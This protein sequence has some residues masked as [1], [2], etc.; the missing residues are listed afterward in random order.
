[1]TTHRNTHRRRT[2]LALGALALV[3]L[4]TALLANAA[5]PAPQQQTDPVV[6][7]AVRQLLD[8]TATAVAQ[9]VQTQTVVAAFNQAVIATAA[10]QTGTAVAQIRQTQ[11][12]V[13]AFNQA[14]TAT[15]AVQ[16]GT[17]VAQI[18]QTQTVVEAFNQ[19]V[20]ATAAAQTVTA[21][22]Q[23]RQTQ[24]VVEA[25]N[26][27]LT[28]TKQARVAFTATALAA[29]TPVVRVFEDGVPMVQVP[30]GCFMMGMTDAEIDDLV[31][32]YGDDFFSEFG[33][34]HQQCFEAPFWI[35]RT[36]VTQADFVR[37]GG[38]QFEQSI[39]DGAD[40]PVE[41]IDWFEAR[42]FCA[43]RGARLPTEAEWEYA[44]RGP[45]SLIYPWGN[46][47]DEGRAVLSG[48]TNYGTAQV[49]SRPAGR[50]WVG[51]DDMVGNVW[52][53]TSSWYGPY[54]YSTDD[55]R[56]ANDDYSYGFS[57][58]RVLRGGAWDSDFYLTGD[59][60]A[61]YRSAN[62]PQYQNTG[63]G[64]RCARSS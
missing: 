17:A 27:A 18:G 44:A 59:Q 31:S 41:N 61:I 7:T 51:A 15:A 40:R 46:A 43:L 55:G 34:Q 53:W 33:P 24:T 29:W 56:E 64:F 35:D 10:V 26:L 48:S 1:M 4:T 49:G 2:W 23:I 39:F 50:S 38:V 12:V 32:Q 14:A 8:A 3:M 63:S 58:V 57:D 60:L 36:E 54:P 37:L 13:E 11:T 6:E 47:F 21:V 62:N 19:A 42:D 30:A 5:I 22:A 16:T 20:T 25:F 52:E 9:I 45:A 28:V